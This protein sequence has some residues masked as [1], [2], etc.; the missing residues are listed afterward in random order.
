M[1]QYFQLFNVVKGD[2]HV[3]VHIHISLW[4]YQ[5]VMY[6]YKKYW[7]ADCD[8]RNAKSNHNNLQYT[9]IYTQSFNF[10]YLLSCYKGHR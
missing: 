8:N 9:H 10:R 1:M 5:N 2:V 7:S 6:V 3:H 4:R